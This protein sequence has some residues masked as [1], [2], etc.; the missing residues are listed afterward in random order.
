[1]L[2]GLDTVTATLDC[3]ITYLA[4]HPERRQAIVDDPELDPG[5]GRGAAA[6][7]DA[8]D[9]GAAQDRPGRRDRRRAC[10]AP[11]TARRCSS[12]RATSTRPSSRTRT[13]CAST[14]AATGTSRSA[15][16][17]TAASARTSRASSCSVALEQFHQRIPEYAIA[18]G[19]EINFSPG[20]RQAEHLPITFPRRLERFPWPRTRGM[21]PGEFQGTIGRY[22][23]ESDAVV[24]ADA[25]RPP[26]GRAERRA[27]RARRRRVRAARLLRLGHRH[28]ELR[29]ARRR[30]PALPQLPHDRAVLADARVPAHRAQ[31]PPNGMGRVT[32]LATGFPGYDGRI[33]TANGVPARDA[34]AARVRGL[35]GRQV[36]P[37]ARG[38]DAPR[39][40]ARDRWPLGRGF[41]RFYGFFGGETHQFVPA[42]V[43]DNHR[44]DAAALGR[45]RLPPHRGPRR[46]RRSS[47]SRDLRARRRRQAV[48]PLLRHRRVPL[49]APGAAGVDR[50][51]PR[52][53]RRGVGRVA[54]ARRFARQKRAGLLPAAH[55]A[56]AA[57]GLGAGV[58]RPRPTTSS[59]VYARYMEAFAGYPVARRRPDRPAARLRSRTIG[60]LDDTL[61]IVLSDN[62]ATSARAA[63]P[64]RSTTAACGT[65]RRARVDEALRAHRRDRRARASTT[66]TRGA[67]RSPATRRSAGGSARCTRAASPTR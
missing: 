36:A 23:W 53:V 10:A 47:S 29:P 41:E 17:R 13:R 31:P 30:R 52:P 61:V 28:A 11:A 7:P 62:G 34:R 45:R 40:A 64:A 49:A 5:R 50:A 46:P 2:G 26:D 39:R 6:P 48:L 58:G 27:R 38:R 18:E 14:A 35:R 51:L 55:R 9:D 42:L 44:V 4:Q 21:E 3:M 19:A 20:I 67:G 24:A 37:H 63:R 59:G 15:A 32:D 25:A 43:H 8:G 60:E 65:A 16:A 57:A 33:P 12:A 1:M 56:V 54:R 66:T 22:H